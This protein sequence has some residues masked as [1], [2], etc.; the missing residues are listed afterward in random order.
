MSTDG[1]DKTLG[2]WSFPTRIISGAGRI[3]EL[4]DA[5]R[6]AGMARPLLITDRGLRDLPIV[7]AALD[8]L[9]AGGLSPQLFAEVRGNPVLG[10]VEVGVR[11][12]QAH[13][14]DGVIAFG[15]GS[16]MDA[17]KAV[18]FMIAQTRPIWDFEDIG[19]YWT[20]ANA[21]GIAPIVAVPTTAGTG[22]EV[23]RAAVIT[24]LDS[25]EKKV[26]F[27][28]K[29][30][31]G[32]VI[33]DPEL[34][35]DLPAHVTAATGMDAFVHCFEAF[36]APAWHPMADGIALEGMRLIA[37]ALPRA[38]T[39]G[40]DIPAR[41]HMQAA[42]AMG[43][44]AFQKGL[45]CVHSLAHPMGSLYD[46]HHGLSNAV[47]LPYVMRM[48]RDAIAGKM[49]LLGRTLNLARTDFNGVFDWVLRFR[50]R[51]DIP[52]SLRELDVPT[53]R[54][55]DIGAMALRDPCTG[56]NPR[57]V[58]PELLRDT[59]LAAHEGAV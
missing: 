14:A 44:V 12:W 21:E 41:A 46:K 35:R 37:D 50:A 33:L 23:G 8:R 36:C 1:D 18:A 34:T 10:N 29:M 20:R 7:T 9:S 4:P 5:C 11:A 54:A 55:A 57:P 24:N 3:A 45:G 48:N 53:D 32:V 38:Y 15:G 26:I 39:D 49:E 47:I 59:F 22:S 2:N 31:P 19:D 40:G 58:T 6:D 56:G 13:A 27:H 17:A 43:A 25:E 52:H 16:A 51:L 28:P 42:A 30:L